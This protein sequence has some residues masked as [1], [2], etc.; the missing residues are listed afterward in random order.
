MELTPAERTA[1]LFVE[2]EHQPAPKKPRKPSTRKERQAVIDA[3]LRWIRGGD[4]DDVINAAL[5]L[6]A[7]LKETGR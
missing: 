6:E 7:K 2:P 1:P 4:Q 3:A 5:V